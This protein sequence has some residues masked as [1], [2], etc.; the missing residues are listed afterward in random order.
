M[1]TTLI[2]AQNCGS[3]AFNVGDK[4][5]LEFK[6]PNGALLLPYNLTWTAAQVADLRNTIKTAMQADDP[7]QRVKLIGNFPEFSDKSSDAIRQEYQDKSSE[8]IM[9][10]KFVWSFM[11]RLGPCAHQ[12]FRKFG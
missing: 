11:H 12:K 4:G 9:D 5:C 7:L 3:L 6:R 2:Q 10:G 8:K 1:G